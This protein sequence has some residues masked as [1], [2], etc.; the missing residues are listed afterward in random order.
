[1]ACSRYGLM[2]LVTSVFFILLANAGKFDMSKP[3]ECVKLVDTEKWFGEFALYKNMRFHKVEGAAI[4]NSGDS[5]IYYK[6]DGGEYC[7]YPWKGT[8]KLHSLEMCTLGYRDGSGFKDFLLDTWEGT[9]CKDNKKA[10]H[11]EF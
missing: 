6:I 7:L 4:R 1:M 3:P 8:M 10:S 11:D 5:P 9:K 2:H